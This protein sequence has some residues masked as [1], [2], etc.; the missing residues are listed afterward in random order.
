MFEMNDYARE[1]AATKI[2]LPNP[3]YSCHPCSIEISWVKEHH[4]S[5]E[6]ASYL[7]ADA[8]RGAMTGCSNLIA[9]PHHPCHPCSKADQLV[10]NTKQ[11]GCTIDKYLPL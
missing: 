8:G 9:N 4:Q 7:P 11:G 1:P 10:N 3:N 2:V 6:I 5:V